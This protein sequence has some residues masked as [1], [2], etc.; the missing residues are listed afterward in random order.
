MKEKKCNC[1]VPSLIAK[2]VTEGNCGPSQLTSEREERDNTH[3]DWWVYKGGAPQFYFRAVDKK[4]EE[5]L[6]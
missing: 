3:V 5:K 2:G 4:D 1:L 6:L